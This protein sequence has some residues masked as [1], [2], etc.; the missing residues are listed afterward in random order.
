M[1]TEI[2]VNPAN[3]KTGFVFYDAD[4]RLCRGLARIGEKV[5]GR[6][7]FCFLPLQAPGVAGRLGLRP[8]ELLIELQ[9]LTADGRRFGGVDAFV[10][11]ARGRVWSRPAAMMA[12]LPW[13]L[14][15][16]RRL[17]A[18]IAANRRCA[19]GACGLSRNDS[20]GQ[21]SPGPLRSTALVRPR[22]MR[23]ALAWI[24]LL[25]LP[26]LTI[27]WRE[28]MPA[29]LF[30]WTLAFAIFAGCKWLTLRAALE[31]GIPLIRRDAWRF[32]LG[33]VG[34]EPREFV[35]RVAVAG[36]CKSHGFGPVV[37]LGLGAGL[38]WLGVRVVLPESELMAGWAG[39]IGMI[40]MLHFG[41]FDLLA[42]AWR[43]AGYPVKPLMRRPT[44]AASVGDFWSTRWNRGFHTLAHRFVYRPLRARWGRT[45][46]M[47]AVF[48]VS[49]LVHDL[50]ISLP[51]GGGFGLP[52]A[53]FLLQ[54]AALW[55]ERSAMGHRLGLGAGWRG[56]WFAASA[57]VLPVGWLFPPDFVHNVILPIL[58]VIGAI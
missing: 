12:T 33:W 32:L 27:A 34:M 10:E 47:L 38:V 30:M 18:W 45:G 48:G 8:E 55:T 14:P 28:N 21:P 2:T 11:M 53:Y 37:R 19:E 42:N 40:L 44:R 54:G 4:C 23:R 36:D 39:M 20:A 57:I 56:R 58:D 46:A 16:L 7:R 52:T 3:E 26:A 50:V 25:V 1:K 31:D 43:S 13:V 49:G 15:G 41:S 9:L 35:R 29:W 22:P 17:Y 6:G 5:V 24:P 51:A